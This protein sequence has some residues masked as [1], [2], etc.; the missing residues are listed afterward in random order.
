MSLGADD[1]RL[2]PSPLVSRFEHSRQRE[3][4]FL[5]R[6]QLVKKLDIDCKRAN[7]NALL[8]EARGSIE[9]KKTHGSSDKDSLPLWISNEGHLKDQQRAVC[10]RPS[11]CSEQ[12]GKFTV[13]AIWNSN[14]MR[15]CL[16]RTFT[17]VTTVLGRAGAFLAAHGTNSGVDFEV[18]KQVQEKRMNAGCATNMDDLQGLNNN[19]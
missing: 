14:D 18:E 11:S 6:Y 1:L 12:Y 4:S 9:D 8:F 13:D 15:F 3:K 2:F 5:L 16:M 7:D 17:A 10:L 19:C